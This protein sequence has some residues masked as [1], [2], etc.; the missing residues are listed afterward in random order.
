V[1]PFRYSIRPKPR[2]GS[3]MLLVA[4]VVACSS[5]EPTGET[6]L[7]DGLFDEWSA[8]ATIL[9]DPRDAADAAVDVLSV[10]GLDDSAWLYL[11]LDVGNE[12]TL[13]SMPG[14]LRLLIDTDADRSTGASEHD[15][16]G[17]DLIV[18]LSQMLEGVAEGR[19]SGFGLRRIDASG[20]PHDVERYALGLIAA[21]T[22]SAPRFELRLSRAGAG[23]VPPFGSRFRM[24]AIYEEAGATPE[25]T[26]VGSYV[27]ATR[28][29]TLARPQLEGVPAKDESATRVVQWNVASGRFDE[30]TAGFATVLAEAEP[31]V[32]LIDEL[33]GDISEERLSEFFD[34]EPLG[35]LGS[36]SFV[37]GKTGD[38]QRAAVAARDREIAPASSFAMV[39]YP[40]R[41]LP[42]L[43]AMAGEVPE[44][45]MRGYLEAEAGR[46]ISAAGAWVDVGGVR[47]LFVVA[48][49]QSGGWDG[50]RQDRLR[51]IQASVLRDHVAQ[52]L[53]ESSAPVVIGGD[54]NL[55]GSRMP[56]FLLTRG[57][58]A[59][60]SDLVPADTRRLG[61]RTYATWRNP[62]DRFTP[63][64]LDFILV[65]D[66]VLVV[67][68]AF[69]FAPEDLDDDALGRLGLD[70]RSL[71][72]SLS[73]H[74]PT[75][76]D[77]VPVPGGRAGAPR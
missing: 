56:L 65:S 16:I 24:K 58:D 41:L 66:A 31:D 36:W 27:F 3:V 33:P 54:F 6:V 48:D 44:E 45:R 15:M 32:V 74:V 75:V 53:G 1:S 67:G 8:A 2:D 25:E 4:L 13:Q 57:L 7:I 55:V 43:A 77:L 20:A 63:G 34:L 69:A 5:S 14:T 49:L 40:E 28:A 12:V 51:E 10:Q 29:G 22:W 73:D 47:T 9:D 11:A 59:D 30:N 23:D 64:R 21:P 71:F 37:L 39:P 19:G 17:V 46:G 52:E 68:D 72:R 18:D 70:R 35:R 62:R 76:A 61:E 60:G 50:S 42:E 38:V 26:E